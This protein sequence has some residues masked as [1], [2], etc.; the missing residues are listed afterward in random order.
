MS[1]TATIDQNMALKYFLQL[2]QGRN[3]E[4]FLK[5]STDYFSNLPRGDKFLKIEKGHS[6]EY[7]LRPPHISVAKAFINDPHLGGEFSQLP[8]EQ[9]L[10]YMVRNPFLWDD[11]AMTLVVENSNASA[12]QIMSNHDWLTHLT[13]CA[14]EHQ[15]LFWK[16]FFGVIKET[17]NLLPGE[18]KTRFIESIYVW[19]EAQVF[20]LQAS[21]SGAE[22]EKMLY[23]KGYFHFLSGY[24][25]AVVKLLGSRTKNESDFQQ[26]F[27]RVLHTVGYHPLAV[28]NL[29]YPFKEMIT[30]TTVEIIIEQLM[31]RATN[32][33]Q[34]FSWAQFY[35]VLPLVTH[36]TFH[37][38][39]NSQSI[40]VLISFMNQLYQL[41]NMVVSRGSNNVQEF[42]KHDEYCYVMQKN[43]RVFEQNKESLI[44]ETMRNAFW[45]LVQNV[46]I[47]MQN[48]S[49]LTD[50]QVLYYST[51]WH[52]QFEQITE[53][54]YKLC[55]C[56]IGAMDGAM[57]RVGKTWDRDDV[58]KSLVKSDVWKKH[59]IDTMIDTY[60]E[61]RSVVLYQSILE[62]P[63]AELPIDWL[64]E[65]HLL[66]LSKLSSKK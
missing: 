36:V 2:M 46:L 64:R 12:A 8:T 48:L 51:E 3:L 44:E 61:L 41:V 20:R 22:T 4:T 24:S 15:E 39:S 40:D 14:D 47:T 30:S 49:S 38:K 62:R 6:I 42:D 19:F 27:L 25:Q 56:Y 17:T 18:R 29:C 28:S 63:D 50:L 35:A 7:G 21:G 57:D 33:S 10:F 16:S 34:Y 32:E 26:L 66:V 43:V 23:G 45:K 53:E 11:L 59:S 37:K 9:Q 5:E 31:L 13:T 58:L 60:T 1:T 65:K 54:N 55:I 52:K